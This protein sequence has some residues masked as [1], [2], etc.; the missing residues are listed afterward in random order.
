M[1]LRR[2]RRRYPLRRC[3]STPHAACVPPAV[4]MPTPPVA[5]VVPGLPA[6]LCARWSM[7]V[8]RV[9]GRR[10]RISAQPTRGGRT[11][12]SAPRAAERGL[13]P[14]SRTLWSSPLDL[15]SGLTTY[16]LS[17]T[18]CTR[19][20]TSPEARWWRRIIHAGAIRSFCLPRR[21]TRFDALAPTPPLHLNQG[22]LVL[23]D[24]SRFLEGCRSRVG[25]CSLLVFHTWDGRLR[26]G[27]WIFSSA[28]VES[29]AEGGG[30]NQ[31]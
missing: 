27:T 7:P 4:P 17:A 6:H 11:P 23:F 1:L 21:R 28:C 19:P 12:G 25:A 29:Q 5:C 3:A 24:A 31:Q 22:D 13:R 20:E 18:I 8:R 2:G 15:A 14:P 30:K 9:P 26:L 16:L 10:P